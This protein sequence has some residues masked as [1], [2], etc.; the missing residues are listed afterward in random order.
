[1]S[2]AS[3]E[4]N[5]DKLIECNDFM[6]VD[7][8]DYSFHIFSVYHVCLSGCLS[9]NASYSRLACCLQHQAALEAELRN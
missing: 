4:L 9:E 8:F 6:C 1:M 2:L 7:C 3:A 5:C